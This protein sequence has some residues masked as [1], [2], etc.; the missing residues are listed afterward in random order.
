[1][2]VESKEIEKS[3]IDFLQEQIEVNA[4]DE[5]WINLLK[6]RKEALNPFVGKTL[7][8]LSITNADRDLL[9]VRF[10]P[11]DNHVVLV[12]SHCQ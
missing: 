5:E 9:W 12:E 11:E 10:N 8:F 4:R 1:M 2:Q 3:Y 7:S 6:R